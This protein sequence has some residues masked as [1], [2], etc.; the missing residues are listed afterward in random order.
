MNNEVRSSYLDGQERQVHFNLKNPDNCDDAQLEEEWNLLTSLAK[1]HGV[2][3][4]NKEAKKKK[5]DSRNKFDGVNLVAQGYDTRHWSI[6]DVLNHNL[7][8]HVPL[9]VKG[10][11]L[12]MTPFLKATS[13]GRLVGSG[14]ESLNA[15]ELAKNLNMNTKTIAPLLEKAEMYGLIRCTREGASKHYSI[16]REYYEC[17]RGEAITDFVKVFQGKIKELLA[18][19]RGKLNCEQWGI[20]ADLLNHMHYESHIICNEPDNPNYSEMKIWR[21]KDIIERLNVDKQTVSKTM[22]KFNELGIIIEIKAYG[23]KTIIMNPEM[24]SRQK[25]GISMEKLKE[26]A[27]T[28]KGNL[29]KG[30]NY[31]KS[32]RCS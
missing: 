12:A 16:E 17:G 14:Q 6:Q 15:G 1:K 24:F 18:V 31:I 5:H 28:Q 21:N 23:L 25:L 32:S 11:V 27:L 22:K 30:K 10:L 20:L 26:V 7:L 2:D 19:R 3:I 4:T 29:S 9:E 13:R 8:K